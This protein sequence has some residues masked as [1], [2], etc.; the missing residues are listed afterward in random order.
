M[1]LLILW[2]ETRHYP[3]GG[4]VA[5]R[6]RS[7]RG[8]A[9]TDDARHLAAGMK[10]SPTMPRPVPTTLSRPI[11]TDGSSTDTT[12]QKGDATAVTYGL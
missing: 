8:R 12:P 6:A 2:R 1:T 10:N 5:G 11:G 3:H 7:S 4:P 9:P